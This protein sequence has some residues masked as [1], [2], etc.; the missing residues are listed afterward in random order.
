MEEKRQKLIEKMTFEQMAY[1]ENLLALP[2][3]EIIAH[4][5][6]YVV[7]EMILQTIPDTHVEET[8]YDKLLSMPDVLKEAEECYSSVQDDYADAV[9]IILVE[10]SGED[11][12][13]YLPD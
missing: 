6:Q 7:R 10:I 4:A 3:E 12:S 11:T 8:V 9:S 5:H 13:N 1:L 2:K